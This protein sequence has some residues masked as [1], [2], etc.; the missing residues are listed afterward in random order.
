MGYFLFVGKGLPIVPLAM[1]ILIMTDA[2]KRPV[3]LTLGDFTVESLGIEYP[4]YFQGYGLGPKSDYSD[5]CYGIGDTEAEALEDCLEMMA[6]SGINLDVAAENRILTDFGIPDDTVSAV[7]EAE[8]FVFSNYP[9]GVCPDCGEDIPEDATAGDECANCG[10]VF[11]RSRCE[12][13]NGPYFHVG[14]K[15]NVR[16]E[17][18]LARILEIPILF[19]LRYED[20]CAVT[21]DSDGYAARFGYVRRVDGNASYGDFKD[22][23]WPASAESY[24]GELSD[25]PEESNEI[26]FYVPYASGSN[27][28]GSAVEKSNAKVFEETYGGNEWVHSVYGG[29]STYAVAVGLTGLLTCDDDTFD[30]ICEDL[31]GLADYPLLN[32]EACFELEMELTDEAWES[33]ARGSFVREL[34]AKFADTAEFEWPDDSTLR[35][36]FEGKRA[37]AKEEWWCEGSGPDMY[38]RIDEVVKGITFDDL[39]TLA[40]Y[41]EVSYNP[42][43]MYYSDYYLESEAIAEVERL[44]AAGRPEA[45]YVKYPSLAVAW[46]AEDA[47]DEAEVTAGLFGPLDA[48]P[49]QDA[50]D[51]GLTPGQI[52]QARKEGVTSAL[53]LRRIE[54]NSRG[55]DTE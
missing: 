30:A 54:K 44:R 26:Y 2:A 16:E 34:E 37:D 41:Y 48:F 3:V 27:Y 32:E 53:G 23:D 1:G 55:L 40:P 49:L 46:A 45:Q 14:I 15:W 39:Y 47:K 19:P 43:G 24:L 29:Y 4:D 10:H 36:F 11:D 5:C 35:K 31:E 21:K 51:M 28:S 9:D 6:Q 7:E 25:D 12:D 20:Y 22:T 13:A 38:V 18:R 52:A 8:C 42:C 50:I 33:W 17:Q